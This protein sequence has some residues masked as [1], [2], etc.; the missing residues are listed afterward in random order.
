MLA[1]G[2]NIDEAQSE[3]GRGGTFEEF[4]P[5]WFENYVV[6]NNKP[7]E[8][9]SKK[10]ALR[11]LLIPFFGKLVIKDI[12]TQHIEEF[13][14]ECLAK[15]QS[16][17]TV[18]NRLTILSKCL[19]TAYEWQRLPGSPPKVKWLKCPPQKTDFLS[20]DECALLLTNS[21]GVIREMIL[22]ALRTGMRHGELAGL[23]WSSINWNTRIITVR[24]AW[25]DKVGTLES[26][27]SNRER[28]IPLDADVY[29]VLFN[30]KRATGFVFLDRGKPWSN[31]QS[32]LALRRVRYKAGLRP[33]TWHTLR[34]TFASHL[35]MRNVPLHVVQQLLGHS[36][37][38]VTMRYAHV[39]PSMLRSAIDALNPKM[40]YAATFG[41]VAVN[42][43]PQSQLLDF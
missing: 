39:A 14:A 41:Q 7:L 1:R 18:N 9:R 29:E 31:K 40:N 3:I 8:Q 26:P 30:R 2:E 11:G 19:S 4:V 32:L 5:T 33:F 38:N 12:T 15:G 42:R 22:V 25:C 10:Y 34:H 37:I 21:E 16:R 20:P 17:K 35:A 23:Q 13:K 27:K 28:H 36:T 43:A 6:P 24:H